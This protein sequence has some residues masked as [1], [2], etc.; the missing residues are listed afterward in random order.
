MGDEDTTYKQILDLYSIISA[1]LVAT[2]NADIMAAR[3][4]MRFIEEYGFEKVA[5]DPELDEGLDKPENDHFGKLKT[6]T[7]RYQ[8]ENADGTNEDHVIHIPALSLIP[9][10]ILQVTDASFDFDI[11]ILGVTDDTDGEI[12]EEQLQRLTE[13]RTPKQQKQSVISS[14]EEEAPDP[15]Q[16]KATLSPLNSSAS[17]S[18][19]NMN[20]NMKV[21][22][23]MRQ[24]DIPAG[25]STLLNVMDQSVYGTQPS[26]PDSLPDDGENL[27]ENQ[28]N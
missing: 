19:S 9:L 4:F 3:Q 15:A 17:E 21:K 23:N 24:A 28:D 18:P 5:S 20:A 12:Q 6:I 22:V 25:I 2:V 13:K 8:T 10:P 16:V 26:A 14:W 1:P 11:R 27:P 7:F